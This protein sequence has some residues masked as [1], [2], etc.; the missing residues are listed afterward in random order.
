ML[1]GSAIGWG[2]GLCEK[3]RRGRRRIGGVCQLQSSPRSFK[4]LS[5]VLHSG[6]IINLFF[7]G[8]AK[9]RSARGLKADGGSAQSG[10]LR[11]QPR[12][13]DSTTVRGALHA[14]CASKGGAQRVE[15]CWEDGELRATPDGAPRA[16]WTTIPHLFS[17]QCGS[18][19]VEL[20]ELKGLDACTYF[21]PLGQR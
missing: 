4:S 16:L 10:A 18:L 2:R 7:D 6:Y 13:S 14:Y 17:E 12:S 11:W 8:R 5:L 21:P 1:F 19:L 9:W 15:T 3:G 20:E